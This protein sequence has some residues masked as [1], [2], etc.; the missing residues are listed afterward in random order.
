MIDFNLKLARSKREGKTV[1]FYFIESG[2]FKWEK[3]KVKYEVEFELDTRNTIE[4]ISFKNLNIGKIVTVLK[5][6]IGR[7]RLTDEAKSISGGYYNDIKSLLFSLWEWG[8][9]GGGGFK[10]YAGLT[11]ILKLNNG[12]LRT[13]ATDWSDHKIF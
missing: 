10:K 6:S 1:T 13:L 7:F 4:K 3:N 11:E 2:L 5:Y 12:Y 9:P 8:R